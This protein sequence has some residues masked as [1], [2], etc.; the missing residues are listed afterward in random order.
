MKLLRRPPIH[1]LVLALFGYLL[2]SCKDVLSRVAL[3]DFSVWQILAL[4]SGAALAVL[5]TY[6][7]LTRGWATLRPRRPW[8]VV[9]IAVLALSGELSFIYVLPRMHLATLFVLLCITPLLVAVLGWIILNEKLRPLQMTVVFIAFCGALTMVLAERGGAIGSMAAPLTYVVVL[10]A[11]TIGAFRTILIRSRGAMEQPRVLL[12]TTM[13]LMFLVSAPL[14]W[15][16]FALHPLD[17]VALL[18]YAPI[19]LSGLLAM[20]GNLL[21]WSSLKLVRAAYVQSMQYSQLIWST[22]AGYLIWA[23]TPGLI[24]LAGGAVVISA[25]CYLI[26]TVKLRVPGQAEVLEKAAGFQ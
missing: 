1:P 2:F 24:T 4:Q 3:H 16:D 18:R 12:L 13:L 15:H 22:L 17:H 14:A 23:E 8:V 21:I 6:T 5:V 7:T 25:G 10:C 20:M 9:L 26:A 11:I 19:C